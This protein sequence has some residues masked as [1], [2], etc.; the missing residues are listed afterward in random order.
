MAD[1]MTRKER[2]KRMSLI[3]SI[4]TKPEIVVRKFLFSK[5][6]RYT[7]HDRKLPG[8]PD[9]VLPKHKVVIQVRGCFWH[10]HYNCKHARLP[11]SNKKFWR[12]KIKKKQVKRHN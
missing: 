2:S 5:G 9:I 10:F 12:E 4:N 1:I 11:K 3:R 7:L 6:F 8:S